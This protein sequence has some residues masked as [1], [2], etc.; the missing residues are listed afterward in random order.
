M[1]N[2]NSKENIE[3]GVEIHL[4]FR[5]NFSFNQWLISWILRNRTD[6][7]NSFLGFN[8]TFAST[9]NY[10]HTLDNVFISEC[11][12]KAGRSSFITVLVT[13]VISRLI[14]HNDGPGLCSIRLVT[15]SSFIF[16][17]IRLK[18]LSWSDSKEIEFR[19]DT[20]IHVINKLW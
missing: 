1:N 10:L 12:F 19:N 7:L 15:Q 20:I 6:Y 3:L 17:E 4:E 13:R 2:F 16:A 8:Y 18:Q 5:K 11:H 9:L 14:W